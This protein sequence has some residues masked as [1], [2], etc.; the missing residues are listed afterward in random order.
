MG[1]IKIEGMEF[2]AHHGHYAEERVVGNKFLINISIKTDCKTAA[3]S[4]NLDD[5]LN[6][7]TVYD[8]ISEQM[9]QKSHLLENVAGRILDAL[10]DKMDGIKSA[11]VK[12]SKMNPPLGGKI[13][14]V[15]VVMKR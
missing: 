3:E 12:V 1:K 15:S 7:Q 8:I 11:K 4:D 10:F 14:R 2:Y 13:D 9:K 5:A 6:Y